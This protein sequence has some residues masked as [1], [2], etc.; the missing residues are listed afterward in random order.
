VGEV[1]LAIGD[2]SRMTHLSVKAL[3]HYHDLGL[4]VPAEVDPA[5]GYRF[6]TPAQVPFAQVIRRLRDLGMPLDEIKEVLRA[7]D[8]ETRNDLLVAHL[9][10]MEAQLAATRSVVDTLRS[11]LEQPPTTV[12]V[13]HRSVGPVRALTIAEQVPA[14][15]LDPWWDAAYRELDAALAAAGVPAA[16]RRAALYP[17]EFFELG[18]G[19]VVAYVPVVA[20][21]AD[22]GRVRLR[23]IPGAELA[24][25]V[26][27]GGLAD[28]DRTY[29]AL[30]TY[31]AG[32]EIGVAGPIRERYLVTAFDTE[33]ESQH[34]TEVCWPVFRT[35]LTLR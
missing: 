1:R 3:R 10:R 18:A 29:G 4:L 28:I 22:R 30:G 27:R 34:V 9:R 6:Y 17:A 24:V 14:S 33:D 20:D 2:F 11:L 21:V 5:S 15:E 26:H 19:E 35:G 31:V 16:G 32:R 25:A 13:E 12:P 8:V 7:A 23:E